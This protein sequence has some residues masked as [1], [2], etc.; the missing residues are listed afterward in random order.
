MELDIF[1]SEAPRCFL[2]FPWSGSGRGVIDASAFP[3]GEVRRRA[4]GVIRR[5]GSIMCEKRLDKV[6]DFAMLF[7]SDGEKVSF[8]GYS[9]FFTDHAGT[10][11][12]N[13]L[14]K[15]ELILDE[16]S[17]SVPKE[18]L[19]ETALC[20]EKIFTELLAMD[21]KGYFGVDMMVYRQGEKLEI[22][23][24]VEVNLRMTMGVVA[25]IWTRR[26][27]ADESVAVMRVSHGPALMKVEKP[28][29]ALGKLSKGRVDLVPP[30]DQFNIVIEA[31]RRPAQNF[32]SSS[33]SLFSGSPI[34]L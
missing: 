7:H 31:V 2:K 6:K 15:D 13:L 17:Q 14:A 28:E 27:L 11:A 34:T 33:Y 8:V 29:I 4:L 16:L 22:A 5:Q 10:Y 3:S 30:N 32:L 18:H 1:L 26:Y 19:E 23:P 12:G 9:L 24:C 20:L 25:W 21:Y